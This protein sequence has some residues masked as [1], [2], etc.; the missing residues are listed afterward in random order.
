MKVLIPIVIGLL[1]MG[2]GEQKTTNSN[3][4]SSTPTIP[5][6]KKAEKETPSNNSTK[7]SS[8]TSKSAKNLTRKDV[9]GV[10]ESEGKIWKLVIH[11]NKKLVAF[12]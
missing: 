7:K 11:E 12:I 2:C 3:E 10:Y 4:S 9:V 1:V 6:K 8:T 5:A